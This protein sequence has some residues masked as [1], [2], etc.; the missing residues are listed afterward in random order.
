MCFKLL[1]WGGASMDYFT[2]FSWRRCHFIKGCWDRD[3]HFPKPGSLYMKS[4]SQPCVTPVWLCVFFIFNYLSSLPSATSLP[5]GQ[6]HTQHARFQLYVWPKCHSLCHSLQIHR[7][8]NLFLSLVWNMW[9]LAWVFPNL[10]QE[11]W[12]QYDISEKC[13]Q[14]HCCAMLAFSRAIIL[15]KL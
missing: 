15:N 7:S 12:E 3:W 6:C 11:P 4:R 2:A 9:F 14:E 5:L 8:T 1:T 13:K 10:S